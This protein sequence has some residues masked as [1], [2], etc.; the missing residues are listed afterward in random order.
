MHRKDEL[1]FKLGDYNGKHRVDVLKGNSAVINRTGICTPF[2][3]LNT[4]SKF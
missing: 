1:I 3:L 2:K 4:A